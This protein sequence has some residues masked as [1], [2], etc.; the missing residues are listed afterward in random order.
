[1]FMIPRASGSS[2][3]RLGDRLLPHTEERLGTNRRLTLRDAIAITEGQ[4]I[5]LS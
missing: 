5:V 1:M 2:S 3:V 4:E